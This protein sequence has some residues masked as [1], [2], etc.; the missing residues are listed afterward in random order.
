M[1][2]L[3]K[4]RKLGEIFYF[5]AKWLSSIERLNMRIKEILNNRYTILGYYVVAS[6]LIFYIA[7][8][9]PRYNWDMIG[10]V[11]CIKKLEIEDKQVL[12]QKV[13]SGLRNTVSADKFSFLLGGVSPEI[14]ESGEYI[15]DKNA[16]SGKYYRQVMGNDA[17]AFYQSLPYY[18]IRVIYLA[19]V[20]LVSALGVDIF[21]AT[22]L[23]S[24]ISVILGLWVLFFTFRPHINNYLL[25]TIPIFGLAFGIDRVAALSGPDGLAFL[26]V[27][28]IA[29]LFTRSNWLIFI[30][31]PLSILVR[32]DLIIFGLI[33]LAYFLVYK[34]SWKYLSISSILTSFVLYF[35]LN[36][37]FGHYG[38]LNVFYITFIEKIT[39][40]VG[41]DI[42]LSAIDFLSV[43]MIGLFS[44]VK[45]EPFLIYSLVSIISL[46]IISEFYNRDCW[47][48][49]NFKIVCFLALSSLL[50]VVIHFALY[51]TIWN[52]FFIG[53]Y[54][55]GTAAFL[56]LISHI[57]HFRKQ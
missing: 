38:W 32:T 25:Y 47:K 22:Y 56:Y 30:A 3:I 10:Y 46:A 41:F 57:N 48:Y 16:E 45:D 23:V 1:T 8:S 27:A 4:Y 20:Y 53:Q 50:Y 2:S 49:P 13:Y 18:Q 26:M 5:S 51:P 24:I 39:H 54:L 36:H 11:G 55:L 15:A 37:Y 12:H 44:L 31:V 21:A 28:I 9:S 34:K 33:I 40:P 7:A 17:E 19:L 29:Y 52:R 35:L 42:Q 14:Y 43:Y 6:I